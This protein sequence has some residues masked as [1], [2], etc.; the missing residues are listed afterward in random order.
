MQ[1][2]VA[3]IDLENQIGNKIV[4]IM[5]QDKNKASETEGAAVVI[6]SLIKFNF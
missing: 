1:E 4:Q 5:K 3:E 6:L 2:W